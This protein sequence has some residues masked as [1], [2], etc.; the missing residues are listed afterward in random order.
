MV[1]MS[2]NALKNA[3]SSS[4]ARPNLSNKDFGRHPAEVADDLIRLHAGATARLLSN[5]HAYW[6]IHG[7]IA[8]ADF[9]FKVLEY[10]RQKSLAHSR[11]RVPRQPS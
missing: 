10:V 5:E 8:K 3:A 2:V 6:L 7:I 11:Q 1:V 4:I 9:C